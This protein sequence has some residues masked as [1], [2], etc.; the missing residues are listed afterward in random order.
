[1]RWTLLMGGLLLGSA[2]LLGFVPS[3]VPVTVSFCGYTNCASGTAVAVFNL[4]NR[5]H[6]PVM[7]ILSSVQFQNDGRW[8]RS[9]SI[10]GGVYLVDA[11]REHQIEVPLP[12]EALRA[13]WRLNFA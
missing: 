11:L 12:A 7:Y 6:Y 13:S 9:E 1:K 2:I 5:R 10:E 4:R 8:H 3:A